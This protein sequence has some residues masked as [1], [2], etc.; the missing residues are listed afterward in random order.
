MIKTPRKS[1]ARGVARHPLQLKV[2]L[3]SLEGA[4]L[5]AVRRFF[6]QMKSEGWQR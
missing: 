1:N 2:E 3:I 4:P 6:Q 5:V